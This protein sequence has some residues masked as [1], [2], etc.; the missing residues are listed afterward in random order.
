MASLSAFWTPN[1]DEEGQK[2][3]FFQTCAGSS[4]SKR[5]VKR[6]APRPLQTQPLL[7]LHL[8][9]PTRKLSFDCGQK[10]PLDGTKWKKIMAFEWLK[11]FLKLDKTRLKTLSVYKTHSFLKLN[12][13]MSPMR[14]QYNHKVL[15]MRPKCVPN[16]FPI[17][18][19]SFPQCVPNASL[20]RFLM[21]VQCVLNV[22]PMR[23]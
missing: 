6:E 2:R 9:L 10:L 18:P 23:P 11:I 20:N 5:R 19:Q 12:A 22:S 17:R 7:P 3:P 4:K 14:P 21:D 13:N 15:P 8:H 16:A 1:D